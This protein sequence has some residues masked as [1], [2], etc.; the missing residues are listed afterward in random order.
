MQQKIFNHFERLDL[1]HGEKLIFALLFH[2][3]IMGK[4]EKPYEKLYERDKATNRFIISVAIEKYADIFNE[5]DPAPFRK[6]DIDHDLRIYLEDSSLDIPL[7]HNI[8]LQF[9]VLNDLHDSEKEERIKTGL[10]TY[11]AFV[12]NELKAKIRK[13]REKSAVYALASFLLLSASYSLRTSVAGGAVLA[14]LFEGINIVGWV[15]LWEAVSTLLF[16]NR[17]VRQRFG[18]YKRFSDAPKVFQH[19]ENG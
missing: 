4:P 15:F 3:S 19:A 1:R 9:K 16:K 12:R 7:K 2:F 13:S 6:R 8:V 14:T 11:F 10:K 18:H 17:D 5:L